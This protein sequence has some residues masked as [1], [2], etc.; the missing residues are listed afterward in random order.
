M[1]GIITTHASAPLD[2]SEQQVLL[3]LV[4]PDPGSGT[5]DGYYQYYDN[6]NPVGSPTLL[7]SYSGLFGPGPGQLDY[8]EAGFVQLAPVP[9]PSSFL[10]LAGAVPGVLGLVRRRR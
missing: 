4:K 3:E 7:G 2:T 9:E 8:T 10:L 5:V 1:T 6:G